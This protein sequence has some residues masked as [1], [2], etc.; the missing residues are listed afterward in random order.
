MAGPVARLARLV[1]PVACPGCGLTDVRW[2]DACEAAWWEPP[3]RCESGAPR[4]DALAPVLPV[5][6][7]TELDGPAHGIVAAWKDEGRRDL[8]RLLRPAMRRGARE[9]A[10]A[11]GPAG[12]SS[13]V[14]VAPCPARAAH[15]RRRGE[16]LPLMLAGAAAAGLVDA[17]VP[18]APVTALAPA[19]GASRGSGD[20]G[21][22][23]AGPS[24]ARPVAWREPAPRP[25]LLVD[26]VLTTGA[27]LARAAA[28]LAG[29]RLVPIGALVLAS[30]P[31]P[32]KV[33]RVR[34]GRSEPALG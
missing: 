30:A 13:R 14:A 28:A 16:D 3:L 17:G 4:L 27:T 12:A 25:V 21:R 34:D 19:T 1:V 23:R 15:T 11:L 10:A 9:V 2:C 8:G 33:L 24:L 26:D 7:I 18:A 31:G 20:R 6:S 32:G 5:W 22:W 29:S